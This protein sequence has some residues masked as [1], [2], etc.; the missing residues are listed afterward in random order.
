MFKFNIDL[1]ALKWFETKFPNKSLNNSTKNRQT[2]IFIALPQAAARILPIL[3]TYF[4]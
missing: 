2:L 4:F 3:L 1:P